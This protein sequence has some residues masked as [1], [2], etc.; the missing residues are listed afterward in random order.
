MSRGFVFR[1]DP[2]EGN[3]NCDICGK[4]TL[5]GASVVHLEERPGVAIFVACTTCAV[6]LAFTIVREF[7]PHP[8]PTDPPPDAPPAS[9]GGSS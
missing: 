6:E 8:P 1:Y 4:P 3:P 9:G 5:G 2:T 7:W